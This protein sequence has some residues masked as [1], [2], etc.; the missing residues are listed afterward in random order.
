MP[1]NSQGHDSN[2]TMVTATVSLNHTG[3]R[4]LLFIVVVFIK[5][6]TGTKVI[7]Q[8]VISHTPCKIPCTGKNSK[9]STSTPFRATADVDGLYIKQVITLVSLADYFVDSTL[10]ERV[11]LGV[12]TATSK[13][14]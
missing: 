5:T 6:V 3:G 1:D 7:F 2:G 8:A 9:P 14:P 12:D 13:T 11:P 10:K 4:L